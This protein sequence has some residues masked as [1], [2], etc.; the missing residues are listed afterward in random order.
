MIWGMDTPFVHAVGG[1][2]GIVDSL[3]IDVAT[4][5]GNLLATAEGYDPILM[6]SWSVDGGATFKGNRQLKLGKRGNYH[7]IRTRGL[8][9]FED[10]GIMFRLRI[11][12]PVIRA[13]VGID[14]NIRPL[15]PI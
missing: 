9:R 4:G 5:V 7:K 2:G 10:K 14:A 6:L 12:D 15:S 3:T 13:I 11:S 8:G 1:N